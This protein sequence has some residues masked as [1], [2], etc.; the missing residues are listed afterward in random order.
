MR[1][2]SGLFF[3]WIILITTACERALPMPAEPT[4]LPPVLV[5]PNALTA[6]P[7]D[8]A[9]QSLV[10]WSLLPPDSELALKEVVDTFNARNPW[11]IQVKVEAPGSAP[12]V[13]TRLKAAIQA[14]QPPDLLI[15][16]DELLPELQEMEVMSDEIGHLAQ[17]KTWHLSPPAEADLYLNTFPWGTPTSRAGYV[18]APV[19]LQVLALAYNPDVLR[20]A[21]VSDEAPRTWEAFE[22][23]CRAFLEATNR[24]CLT[25]QPQADVFLNLAWTLGSTF[26]QTPNAT[27]PDEGLRLA[28]VLLRALADNGAALPLNTQ[29]EAL[30]AALSGKAAFAL[31]STA[32]LPPAEPSKWAIAPPPAVDDKPVLLASSFLMVVLKTGDPNRELAAWLFVRDY[33]VSPEQQARLADANALPIGQQAAR[34]LADESP[35]AAAFEWLS[36][37]RPRP[38]SP[39]WTILAPQMEQVAVQLLNRKLSPDEAISRLKGAAE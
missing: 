26:L 29:E 14:G 10:L 1:L 9:A 30:K 34:R 16:P 35:L 12:E 37:A 19:R 21:G 23:S 22:G 38:L 11:R 2:K 8:P 3:L 31:V 36:F 13:G 17:E 7:P 33:L 25:F 20:K 27:S 39:K 5:S 18:V 24:P 6:E 15:V 28:A 4:P 32:T